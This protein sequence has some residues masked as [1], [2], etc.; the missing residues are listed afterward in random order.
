MIVY[1]VAWLNCRIPNFCDGLGF[2]SNPRNYISRLF[3]EDIIN[4]KIDIRDALYVI[5][6]YSM[7]AWPGLSQNKAILI[8][9][10]NY[11]KVV[12]VFFLILKF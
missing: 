5:L 1:P 11:E 7:V 10:T 8:L 12:F 6:S 9:L 3:Y 2:S 4:F